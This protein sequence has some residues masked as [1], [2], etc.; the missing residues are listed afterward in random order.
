MIFAI[1]AALQEVA[2]SKNWKKISA[3]QLCGDY[4]EPAIVLLLS[5]SL[6][7]SNAIERRMSDVI[8]QLSALEEVV[9]Q[10]ISAFLFKDFIGSNTEM[11]RLIDNSYAVFLSWYKEFDSFSCVLKSKGKKPQKAQRSIDHQLN[12]ACKKF[13]SQEELFAALYHE[14]VLL[15]P[16][17]SYSKKCLINKANSQFNIVHYPKVKTLIEEILLRYRA[18]MEEKNIVDLNL[19]DLSK[20]EITSRKSV[21]GLRYTHIIWNSDTPIPFNLKFY[22]EKMADMVITYLPFEQLLPSVDD[23]CQDSTD[24]VA[25]AA[26]PQGRRLCQITKD[27]I[28]YANIHINVWKTFA[29]KLAVAQNKGDFVAEVFFKNVLDFARRY[30][31]EKCWPSVC[32]LQI[33]NHFLFLSISLVELLFVNERMFQA[34]MPIWTKWSR[35]FEGNFADLLTD[36]DVLLRAVRALFASSMQELKTNA[37][38]IDALKDAF[39]QFFPRHE[40]S[41]VLNSGLS[42][43]SST[44]L[45]GIRTSF[46]PKV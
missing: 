7:D 34:L 23:V 17:S 2:P 41:S 35:L 37:V 13:L 31:V 40:M 15:A 9:H 44:P 21:D 36:D 26:V 45:S 10:P 12:E 11:P 42:L 29:T 46:S 28:E 22:L 38:L 19:S 32:R 3:P 18:W 1:R 24:A 30:P 39:Y 16:S 20:F 43:F 25:V 27:Y 5:S 33:L 14:L 4:I 8:A 6:E